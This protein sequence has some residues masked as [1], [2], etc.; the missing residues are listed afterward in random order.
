MSQSDIDLA[1]FDAPLPNR[2][3]L[4]DYISDIIQELRDLSNQAECATLAG[5][6]EVARLEAAQQ[7]AAAHRTIK[8]PTGT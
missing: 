2:A 3:D 7:S 5:I 8:R 4:L 1:S 6:L